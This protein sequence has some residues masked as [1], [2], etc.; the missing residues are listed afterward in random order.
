MG[1]TLLI[2]LLFKL[3]LGFSFRETFRETINRGYLEECI[4][5]LIISKDERL[6]WEPVL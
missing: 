2:M 4:N 6:N 1:F 3:S 5:H